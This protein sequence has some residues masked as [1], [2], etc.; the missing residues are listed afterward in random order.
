MGN[1]M[2]ELISKFDEFCKLA[3]K[4]LDKIIK[5]GDLSPSEL[6]SAYKIAC[7]TEKCQ[8]V[9]MKN[10]GA[11]NSYGQY[12]Y[13]DGFSVTPNSYRGMYGDMEGSYSEARGR[14]PVTG[15]YISRGMGMNSGGNGYSGHSI[16]DRM[17][18]ALEQQMDEAKTEYERKMIQ[19]EIQRIRMGTR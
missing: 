16:E 6:E 1:E 2:N 5:K 7:M 9:K 4:E 10:E 12:G 18:S 17:I 14:S 8:E 3:T 11:A 19:D 15:R 13:M